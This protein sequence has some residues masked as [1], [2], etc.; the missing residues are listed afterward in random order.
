MINLHPC[1]L[2]KNQKHQTEILPILRAIN[3][4]DLLL[5]DYSQSNCISLYDVNSSDWMV[6]NPKVL[7]DQIK[8]N[9]GA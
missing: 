3:S 9:G 1:G 5:Q 6:K 2:L 7:N 8:S 4:V